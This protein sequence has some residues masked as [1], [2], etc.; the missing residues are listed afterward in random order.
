MSA[1]VE[2]E[3]E[4]S[5]RDLWS[6]LE[7]LEQ[8]RQCDVNWHCYEIVDGA[9][10]VSPQAGRQHEWTTIQLRHA[11]QRS[12][13]DGYE[14]SH[15]LGIELGRSYLVPDLAILPVRTF[16]GPSG[17]P[18]PPADVLLAVEVVSPGSVSMDRLV[19]PAQYAAGG[20]PYYWRVELEPEPSLTAYRLPLAG[21]T[22]SEVGIWRRGETAVLDEPFPVEVVIDNLL[23]ER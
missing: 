18:V 15:S 22:Y 5:Y 21:T 10:V 13:P 19:K 8:E 14:I 23:P 16:Q 12:L 2:L 17:R 1:T 7:S 6:Y 3:R 20:V 4:W 9:L 11:T